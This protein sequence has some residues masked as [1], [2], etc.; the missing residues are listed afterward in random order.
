MGV[1]VIHIGVFTEGGGCKYYF[2]L[3]MY[4]FLGNIALY[5]ERLSFIM[6]ISFWMKSQPGVASWN[7]SH[8]K[9]VM[10]FCSIINLKKQLSL[11]SF[12]LFLW[13]ISLGQSQQT[14]IIKDG[15]FRKKYK[16]E[17]TSTLPFQNQRLFILFSFLFQPPGQHQQ[18]GKWKYFE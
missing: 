7:I 3:V 1:G 11:M 8:K 9:L 14:N 17:G 15:D 6:F 2:S 16:K 5:L 4:G 13:R 12:I 18:N 10:L